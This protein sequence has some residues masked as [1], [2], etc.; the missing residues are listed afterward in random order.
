MIILVDDDNK[1]LDLVSINISNRHWFVFSRFYTY[2]R[3]GAATIT[4]MEK[5]TYE[6]PVIREIEMEE[7][8]MIPSSWGHEE[9]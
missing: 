5:Q 8:I 6:K 2:L 3:T 1:V 7:E 4:V 9:G